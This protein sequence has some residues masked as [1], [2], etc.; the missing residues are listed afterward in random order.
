[1]SQTKLPE[2]GIVISGGI[3][4]SQWIGIIFCSLI[5]AVILFRILKNKK[6]S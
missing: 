1:M 5:T 2:T 4:L 3:L 6:E